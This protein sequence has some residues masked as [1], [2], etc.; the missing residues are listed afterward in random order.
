[1]D[2]SP[3]FAS[4]G[5]NLPGG[6][7]GPGAILGRAAPR[8]H[9][10]WRAADDCFCDAPGRPAAG[11]RPHDDCLPRRE[12]RL[13]GLER[14]LGLGRQPVR[15]AARLEQQLEDNTVAEGD[16]EVIEV[17]ELA[18]RPGMLRL[19]LQAPQRPG[20]EHAL[21]LDLP[22]RAV[23]PR[24][25]AQGDVVTAKLRPYGV[26]FARADTREPFLLLLA[27]DWRGD[28]DPQAVTL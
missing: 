6:T 25:I 11:R 2:A 9:P 16:Y 1:L 19:R 8:R 21:F 22:Q 14:R 24:G 27:D 23:A 28:L 15:L 7:R 17:A 20:D 18:Q 5:V 13:V 12:L 3:G 26:E 4:G 10:T